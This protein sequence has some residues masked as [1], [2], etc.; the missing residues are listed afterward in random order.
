MTVPRQMRAARPSNERVRL[1]RLV[2]LV[3]RHRPEEIGL[4]LDE[5]G[6]VPLE[7]L[8]RAL[9]TQGGWTGVTTD[10]LRALAQ[11]DPRRYEV[12]DDRI[13]ARYGHTVAV[14]RPGEPVRP[15][16][17]LYYGLSPA[18]A[19][20]VARLG[21]HPGERQHVH[22]ATTPLAALEVGRRRSAD[23]VVMVVMA[24]N[25]WEA[26]VEFWRAGPGIY[27]TP[28][29]P[30]RF[31]WFPGDRPKAGRASRDAA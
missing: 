9:A 6:F 20:V 25:A 3:L 16:E 10:D 28:S 14:A 1:S 31:L 17:W 12:R 19:A 22:L 26:G 24:R 11:A 7:A 30:A 4:T 21:L 27:L 5:D 15:P 18:H 2:A 8:A 13:R 29:V 23:A